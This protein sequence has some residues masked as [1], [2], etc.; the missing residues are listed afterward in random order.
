[1]YVHCRKYKKVKANKKLK[2][3]HT[4][5]SLLKANYY[6]LSGICLAQI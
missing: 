4:M 6:D 2:V 5:S 3:T 1:M